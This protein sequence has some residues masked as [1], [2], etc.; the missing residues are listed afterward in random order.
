MIISWN[1]SLKNYA[2]MAAVESDDLA[3]NMDLQALMHDLRQVHFSHIWHRLQTG[4][5]THVPYTFIL[6]I[7]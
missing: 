1:A 5:A 2:V 3:F 7:V 4:V 6:N